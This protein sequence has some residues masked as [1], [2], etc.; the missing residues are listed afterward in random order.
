[1]GCEI[2][3]AVLHVCTR[4]ISSAPETGLLL[5]C[6]VSC[7]INKI[8]KILE[9]KKTKM[10]QI[11][12]SKNKGDKKTCVTGI[13]QTISDYEEKYMPIIFPKYFSI[14]SLLIM[15]ISCSPSS[16][17]H[18]LKTFW[19]HDVAYLFFCVIWNSVSYLPCG[20]NVADHVS[21]VWRSGILPLSENKIKQENGEDAHLP[22]L[23]YNSTNII[24]A[25]LFSWKALFPVWE[26]Y[27]HHINFNFDPGFRFSLIWWPHEII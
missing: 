3:N 9:Y 15:P 23:I 10:Y 1:M 18:P 5:Y 11:N 7:N 24:L 6:F 19:Y 4:T 14:A 16:E 2:L 26:V 12:K 25:S 22:F 8:K 20:V 27:N 21:A 13:K 17:R